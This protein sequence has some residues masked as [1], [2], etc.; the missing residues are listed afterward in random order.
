MFLAVESTE[1]IVQKTQSSLQKLVENTFNWRTLMV[2]VVAL[3]SAYLL[4]QIV[5][6]VLIKTAKTIGRYGDSAKTTERA[7]Q[8]RRLETYLSIAIALIRAVIF[9]TAVFVAWSAT[10]S[11]SSSSAALIGASTVFVVLG[12]AT[13]TPL[14]RDFT[15]GSL[16]IAERWYNVG[17]FI[18]VDPYYEESGVVEQMNLRSTKIRKMNGEALWIHNQYIQRVSV[19][20]TGVRTSA[21]DL[22]VTDLERGEALV[23][24]LKGILT[25]SPTMLAKPLEIA[26]TQK[27]SD[28][29]WEITIIGQTAPGREWLL[30]NFAVSIIK[31]YDEKQSNGKKIIAYEPLV[32]Y[33]DPEVEK[34]FKRAVRIRKEKEAQKTGNLA[35]IAASYRKAFSYAK[36]PKA[37]KPKTPNA[38]N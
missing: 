24:H 7:L 10:H 1:Q 30:E 26:Y 35:L 38:K 32:R 33:A 4:S 12:G 20:T 22:F 28:E 29:L 19:S 21:I 18:T 27:L 14:L 37:A 6:K 31:E 23:N 3:V 16:M 17:D 8:F 2:F 25:V 9:A 11:E 5:A 34:R 13:I 15:A 36:T